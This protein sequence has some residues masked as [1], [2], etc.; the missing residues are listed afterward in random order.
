MSTNNCFSFARIGMVMKRDFMENW[1]RNLYVFLGIFIAFLAVYLFNMSAYNELWTE[2]YKEVSQYVNPHTA[3]FAFITSF[4]LFYFVTEMMRNMRTKENRLSYLMLPASMLEK[5]VSRALYVTVG[6]MLMVFVASL[7][8][9]AV[10]W[11]FMPFFDDIP[12]KFRICVWPEAWGNVWETINPFQKRVYY[13]VSEGTSPEVWQRVEK[14]GFFLI[15][16]VYWMALWWHSLYIIGGNYFGKYAF[17]KTTGTLILLG[18]VIGYMLSNVNPKECFGWFEEFVINNE[19]W[20]TEEVVAGVVGF[21]IFCFTSFNWWL[22][23]KLF[24]RRQVI[25]PKFRLL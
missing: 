3:S 7:L 19:E 8:A 1:K 15:M 17:F 21:I 25:E 2:T 12:D 6:T 13:I 5:F 16:M 11:V 20:L 10:H 4:S 18:V 23:Y 24:T 9:E 22:S 14:S